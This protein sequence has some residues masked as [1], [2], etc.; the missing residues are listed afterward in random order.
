MDISGGNIMNYQATG[1]VQWLCTLFLV[2]VPEA[3]YY[4][5]YFLAGPWP[6]IIILALVGLI[7]LLLRDWWINFIIK[8]FK[9]ESGPYFRGFREK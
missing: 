9:R 6:A 3:I 7:C 4:C 5:F 2:L 1:V 8:G